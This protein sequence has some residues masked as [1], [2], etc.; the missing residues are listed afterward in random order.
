MVNLI[1]EKKSDNPDSCC[2][3]SGVID[4]SVLD[5][6]KE[7]QMPG[8]PDIRRT[9]MQTYLESIPALMANARAAIVS[10]DGKALRNSAHS[11]KSSSL[12]I[13]AVL[14]GKTCAELEQLGKSNTLEDTPAILNRAENELDVTF[15]A[16]RNALE[17]K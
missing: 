13:G 9:L 8:R 14:F 16:L 2:Q 6:L 10:S 7:L 1:D 12:S 11:M 3:T 17:C 4:W 5:D 15:A